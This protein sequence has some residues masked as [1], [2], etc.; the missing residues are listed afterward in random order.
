MDDSL[1]PRREERI[2]LLPL[3]RRSVDAPSTRGGG[4][5]FATLRGIRQTSG[6]MA[7]LPTIVALCAV[8]VLLLS[9]TEAS[10]A[11]IFVSDYWSVIL[12]PEKNGVGI[13]SLFRSAPRLR[14]FLRAPIILRI[15]TSLRMENR[16]SASFY[17][18]MWN[19]TW[20]RL[21][22]SCLNCVCS[23][24]LPIPL[25]I[26]PSQTPFSKTALQRCV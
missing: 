17:S 2:K 19:F 9:A 25:A 23:W 26:R 14:L 18:V 21:F 8:S 12:Q 4:A 13:C 24:R 1:S 11:F 10:A 22:D 5:F 15:P 3:R 7:P 16:Y 20:A 6:N